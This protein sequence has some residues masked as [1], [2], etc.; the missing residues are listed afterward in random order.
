MCMFSF[1]IQ[2]WKKHSQTFLL[3]LNFKLW[4]EMSY[5]NCKGRK[6]GVVYRRFPRLF[7][8]ITAISCANNNSN[9]N[10]KVT[11]FSSRCNLAVTWRHVILC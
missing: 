2:S 5:E 8:P 11:P 4:E 9:N 10:N 6:Q 3:C 1:T 7:L